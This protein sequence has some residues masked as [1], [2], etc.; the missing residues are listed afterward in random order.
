MAPNIFKEHS[1]HFQREEFLD[2]LILT[3]KAPFWKPLNQ[4]QSVTPQKMWI[5]NCTPVE[6]SNLTWSGI[7]SFYLCGCKYKFELDFLAVNSDGHL[8]LTSCCCVCAAPRK[9]LICWHIKW[10]SSGCRLSAVKMLCHIFVLY[11]CCT[12]VTFGAP[13]IDE[14]TMV[15]AHSWVFL[16]HKDGYRDFLGCNTIWFDIICRCY[17]HFAEMYCRHQGTVSTTLFL[18]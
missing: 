12:T 13:V 14:R 18:K 1:Y 17:L 16:V 7:S 3:M 10:H 4:W 15:S 5:L 11:F 9:L 6:T 2:C 8:R